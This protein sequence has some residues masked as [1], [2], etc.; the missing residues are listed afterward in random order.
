MKYAFFD[1]KDKK[2]SIA[3][4]KAI[5]FFNLIRDEIKNCHELYGED[6]GKILENYYINIKKDDFYYNYIRHYYAMRLIELIKYVKKNKK[7]LDVGCGTGTEAIFCGI[8]GGKVI[9]ID[10]AKSRI[11][12][13][14]KRHEYF[15][16]MLKIKI[17][18]EFRK[19]NV[20]KHSGMYDLIWVNEAISHIVPIEKF[21]NMCYS[22][23]KYRGNIIIADSNK[24]NPI[25]YFQAKKEQKKW[26]GI[27]STITDK[28]T[29]KK[30]PIAVERIYPIPTIKYLLSKRF[31]IIKVF[32]FGY[33]PFFIFNKFKHF[34]RKI[35]KKVLVKIPFLNL[36]SVSYV[37][38][39]S[40]IKEKNY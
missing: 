23:L 4:N 26:G 32:P 16:N 3:Y 21:F 34:C 29:G 22:F 12:V 8:L 25:N 13:A 20:F 14:K 2:N 37:I 33:F 27:F 38:I 36:L 7:I 35:E 10:I 9:G 39:C 31:K 6:D 30:I 24:I 11:N 28:T 19:E 18:V 40:K 17:D 5:G 1:N 15:E